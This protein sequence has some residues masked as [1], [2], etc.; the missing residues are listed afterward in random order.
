MIFVATKL[1]L[2][3]TELQKSLFNLGTKTKVSYLIWGLTRLLIKK[4]NF[5]ITLLD[6]SALIYQNKIQL[7][8]SKVVKAKKS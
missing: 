4:I 6:S 1:K 7:S 8:Q 3:C 2:V 5:T